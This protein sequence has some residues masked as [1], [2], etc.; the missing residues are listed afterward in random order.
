MAKNKRQELEIREVVI[1]KPKHVQDTVL[2]DGSRSIKDLLAPSS[3]TINEDGETMKVDE[4]YV[5]TL[6]LSGIRPNTDIGWLNDLYNYPGDMD[7]AVY[8]EPVDER[9]AIDELTKKISQYETQMAIDR[10]KGSIKNTTRN[11]AILNDLYA[12]RARLEQSHEN[13][14]LVEILCNMFNKDRRELGKAVQKLVSRMAGQKNRLMP[15]Y[16]RQDEGFRSVL[17][18]GVNYIDDY[19]RNFGTGAVGDCFP[20]YNAEFSQETGYMFALNSETG[21]PIYIDP[22]DRSTFNNANISVFGGS[23]AGKTYC[24]SLILMHLIAQGVYG[25]VIDADGEFG[26]C[27]SAMNGD[28]LTIAPGEYSLNPFDIE[29]EEETTEDGE[30]TG[31]VWVDVKEKVA[32]LMNMV[33]IM[34]QAEMRGDVRSKISETLLDLYENFGITENPASLYEEVSGSFDAATGNFQT[35]TRKKRMPQF[36]DFWALLQKRAMDEKDALLMQVVE[37]LSIFVSGGLYDMFDCQTSEGVNIEYSHLVV[38]NV[39]KLEESI[40]RPIGMYIVFSWVWDKFIKKN[41]RRQKVVVLEEAWMLLKETLAGSQ[42][43]SEFVEKAA[44]RIRKRNGSLIVSSQNVREFERSSHGQAVLDNTTIKI[45]LKQ[46]SADIAT[47]QKVFQLSEGEKKTLLQAK[48]GDC[49]IKMN[50]ISTKGHVFAF[51]FEDA[52]IS[53]KYLKNDK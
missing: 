10:E 43:T 6:V 9:I 23:G 40:L 50:E 2:A 16:L 15:L 38:F 17:P 31:R 53:K 3:I 1:N 51:P 22:Y 4:Q 8:V 47:T 18:L 11:Q 14:F 46:E 20:F 26:K 37:A 34:V 35:G 52:L 39:S 49:L 44:R 36:S 28:Y 25:V 33:S 21:T 32:D 5:E 24:V 12:Q 45:L 29:A 48:R 41:P 7:T 13:M 19:Y 42:Y 30:P 27:T